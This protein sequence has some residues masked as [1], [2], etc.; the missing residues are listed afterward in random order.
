[1]TETKQPKSFKLEGKALEVVKTFFA[2]DNAVVE[3]A[4]VLVDKLNAMTVQ[5]DSAR[6]QMWADLEAAMPELKEEHTNWR[7]DCEH[8]EQHGVAII[9][10]EVE[11]GPPRKLGDILGAILG[12]VGE[13]CKCPDCTAERA[14]KNEKA[15]SEERDPHD[16]K[17]TA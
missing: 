8:L 10:D 6:K 4:N 9:T 13:Q 17:R 16:G 2:A 15:E 3:E 7:L 11:A 12:Q 1:M 5:R 14:A